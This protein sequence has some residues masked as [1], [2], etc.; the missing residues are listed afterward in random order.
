LTQRKELNMAG[1]DPQNIVLN[2]AKTVFKP[3]ESAGGGP[4]MLFPAAKLMD[5]VLGID[6]HPVPAPLP[7]PYFGPVFLWHSPKFPLADVFINNLPATTTGAMGYYAHIPQGLPVE[8][9]NAPYWTRYLTNIAMALGLILLTTAANMAIAAISAAIVPKESKAT[10][11]FIQDVTGI[12][13]S[14]KINTFESIKAS[15]MAYTQWQTWVR[16]L[17]PPLPY[18]GS[19]GSVAVGSANVFVNGAPLA[20]TAPLVAAS[21]SMIPIV[22]NAMT[23]GFSNV[24]VGVGIADLV[25][26]IAVNAAQSAVSEGVGAG[27]NK[28]G[29]GKKGQ[30]S[31]GCGGQF[32]RH[33]RLINESRQKSSGPSGQCRHRRNVSEH[34]GWSGSRAYSPRMGAPLQ[35]G[36]FVQRAGCPGARLERPLFLQSPG[37]RGRYR[38][39]HPGRRAGPFR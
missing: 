35:H 5:M 37:D 4:R 38:S 30:R 21:C 1:L 25:R 19:N 28:A 20:F 12:D 29:K 15:F 11:S 32:Y 36:C 27:L 34:N 33:F 23:L 39:D 9:T 17:L 10:T 31:C 6:G 24:F 7:H 3:S 16:L 14:S 13:T 2:P 26:G 18:P 22:P 8:P